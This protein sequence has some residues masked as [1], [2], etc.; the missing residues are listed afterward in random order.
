MYSATLSGATSSRWRRRR[1]SASRI[2][3]AAQPKRAGSRSPLGGVELARGSPE[4][5]VGLGRPGGRVAGVGVSGSPRIRKS[6][7][8]W[9]T[10]LSLESGW[11]NGAPCSGASTVA[12]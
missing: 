1:A 12:T 3:Q 10:V 2:P 11:M 7:P 8:C 5:G 4:R 6:K 9:T